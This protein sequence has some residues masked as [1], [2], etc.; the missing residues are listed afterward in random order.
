MTKV[1]N[2]VLEFKNRHLLNDSELLK[3]WYLLLK[4]A[5]EE[6]IIGDVT[7]ATTSEI[8]RRIFDTFPTQNRAV[9][10]ADYE[11][12]AYRMA[13]KFGSLKRCSV[14]RDPDSRKTESEYVC[15][16]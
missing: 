4:I 9:T 12:L 7:N 8:K 16:F 14:Q 5:N 11:N 3:Q 6:P 15:Y 1:S 10:Q 2:A 13:A